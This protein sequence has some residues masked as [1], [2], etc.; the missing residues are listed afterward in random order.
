[1]S[2]DGDVR[3]ALQM[4][5]LYEC[6]RARNANPRSN[7]SLMALFLLPME[8]LGVGVGVG[9]GVGVRVR[10]RVRVR[11]GLDLHLPM[12]RLI[13]ALCRRSEDRS[14]FRLPWALSAPRCN[15]RASNTTASPG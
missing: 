9:G 12:D 7:V 11:G 3:S 1:M 8:R 6:S 14:Q 2:V 4:L 10:V 5:L 15:S 13:I